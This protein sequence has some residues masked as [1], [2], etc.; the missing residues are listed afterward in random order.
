MKGILYFAAGLSIGAAGM[1]FGVH[2][3][4]KKLSE[5]EV[6]RVRAFYMNKEKQKIEDAQKEAEDNL[7]ANVASAKRVEQSA[8][9]VHTTRTPVDYT[10]YHNSE[11][12]DESIT[13]IS[14]LMD[15]PP[16][17]PISADMFGSDP[18]VFDPVYMTYNKYESLL[19]I[20]SN[21]M[22]VDP[23]NYLGEEYFND[24]EDAKHGDVLH[25][26]DETLMNDY[27]IDIIEDVAPEDE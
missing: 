12:N 26:R 23:V 5:E 9:E 6:A 19:M 14:Q 16:I 21:H 15:H 20:N 18:D 17:Y 1:W 27:C 22:M 25:F 11:N 10:K 4:Y 13:T 7:E 2:S 24:L 3:Y 8:V